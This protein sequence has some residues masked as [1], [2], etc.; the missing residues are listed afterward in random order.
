MEIKIDDLSGNELVKL[1]A[2]HRTQMF[3]YSPPES[4]H[5]LDESEMHCDEMTFWSAWADGEIL[6]CG[7]LKDLGG[8]H[9][10]VK[11]MRTAEGHLR[12][13]VARNI[14]T[15]MVAEARRRG[16]RR[17][18]LETGSAAAFA[19]ARAMYEDFGFVS[20]GPFASYSADPHSVFMTLEL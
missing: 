5:A 9:G 6:G 10:E 13:G 20:C 8:G 11:S 4:V 18:S 15:E 3:A 14:L 7:G 17:L 16:W 12:K 19:P 1:L 2:E